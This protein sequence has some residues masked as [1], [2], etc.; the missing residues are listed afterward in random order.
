MRHK[1][2]GT[3]REN[4]LGIGMAKGQGGSA[5]LGWI[6]ATAALVALVISLAMQFRTKPAP[7]PAAPVAPK[8]KA[9]PP[10]LIP[11]PLPPLGRKEL[12]ALAS[13]AADAYAAGAPPPSDAVSLIGRTFVIAMPIGC[14]G[15]AQPG[16]TAWAEWSYDAKRR[17]L[18]LSAAP[19]QWGKA[20]WA[21]A[22][23]KD[24]PFDAIEGFWVRRPWT[25]AESC[26]P[27]PAAPP[28]AETPPAAGPAQ[29]PVASAPPVP[30][31]PPPAT[32]QTL[33]LA[34]I[35]AP[36][37]PRT[38]QR[39]GRP[40]RVTKKIDASAPSAAHPYRLSVSGRLSGFAD[41]QPVHCWSEAS[42]VRPTCIIAIEF[43]RVAFEDPT[44]GA[45][46]SEWTR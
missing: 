44:N 26:P 31:P 11:A 15:P 28:P 17:A 16:T 30:V 34:Q 38:L 42:N 6:V 25:S 3:A 9:P 45:T 5:R 33:G 10:P 36:G 22:I 21:K 27:Q 39:G 29:A 14:E 20:V 23:T 2:G 18:K 32:P 12:L 1:A 40:Y 46:V 24:A 43:S 8:A 19:E 7:P 37:T 35:F 41:G 13:A 4:R